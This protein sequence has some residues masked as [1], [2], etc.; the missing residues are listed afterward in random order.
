MDGNSPD[1]ENSTKNSIIIKDTAD[2]YISGKAAFN[3]KLANGQINN[4]G[5]YNGKN[6]TDVVRTLP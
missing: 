6:K 4:K 5:E 3:I 1:N 2:L